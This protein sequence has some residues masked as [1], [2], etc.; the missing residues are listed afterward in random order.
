[1]RNRYV[2]SIDQGTTRTK[3]ALFDENGQLAGLGHCPVP[4]ILPR[5]GWVEQDPEVIW[6][7]VL[8]SA[9]MAMRGASCSPEQVAAVGVAH[10]GETVVM[11]SRRS[12]RPLYN[13]ISWQCRR[14]APMCE[15]LKKAGF[16]TS[17]R[18]KTG[19]IIDPYFSA[20]KI[21]W[22]LD[23]V[24]KAKRQSRT[25]EVVCGTLD[26]WIVWKMS[27]GRDFVTDY[28]TAARTMLFNIHRLDWDKEIL[29]MVGLPANI[30]AEPH[31]N[32]DID[33]HTDSD[34]FLGVN[35]PIPCT[36]PDSNGALF[37]HGCHDKGDVKNTYGTGCFLLMN[38]GK[39]PVLCVA[40]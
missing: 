36:I 28:A 29:D 11:W 5:P 12:G 26:T 39:R 30:L 20:T 34:A 2:L 9:R 8:R 21:K 16:E 24:V 14:T 40:T 4:R 1:M 15:R 37:G 35:A 7:S 19:L 33:A 38:T 10:Q 25:G 3:A 13:A 32:L 6:E 17:V 23:N 18:R 31:A 27:K 22:I